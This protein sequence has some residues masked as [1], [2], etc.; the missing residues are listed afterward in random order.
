MLFIGIMIVLLFGVICLLDGSNK[1]K[2]MDDFCRLECI[3]DV[4]SKY[5]CCC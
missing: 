5:K 4:K 1:E 2:V 3:Q